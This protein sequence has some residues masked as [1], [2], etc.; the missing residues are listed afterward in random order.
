[1]FS[2]WLGLVEVAGSL[3]AASYARSTTSRPSIAVAEPRHEGGGFET[4]GGQNTQ[5]VDPSGLRSG[6]GRARNRHL[7][8]LDSGGRMGLMAG[9]LGRSATMFQRRRR[10]TCLQAETVFRACAE[11]SARCRHAR[12][13]ARDVCHKLEPKIRKRVQTKSAASPVFSRGRRPLPPF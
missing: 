3:L 8:I 1:M 5:Q 10:C 6:L 2:V 11:C 12:R 9:M 4:D 13:V 7:R